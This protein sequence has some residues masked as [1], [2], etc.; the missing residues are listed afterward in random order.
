MLY[1]KLTYLKK[2]GQLLVI[3]LKRRW[4]HLEKAAILQQLRIFWSRNNFLVYWYH[5]CTHVLLFYL[6]TNHR[7]TRNWLDFQDTFFTYRILSFSDFFSCQRLV[8]LFLS[9]RN[10]THGK[11]FAHDHK[12]FVSTFIKNTLKSS[13]SMKIDAQQAKSIL[14]FVT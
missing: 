1:P 8:K 11:K 14:I 4:K 3:S 10:T 7:L 13:S 12:D 5:L 2:D 6:E 9:R